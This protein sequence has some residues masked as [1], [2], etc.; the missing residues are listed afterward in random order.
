MRA[1]YFDESQLSAA[2]RDV[3]RWYWIERRTIAEVAD[4]LGVAWAT[5]RR[6]VW[7][8]REYARE[9]GAELEK[10]NHGRPRRAPDLEYVGHAD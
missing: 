3:Y 2:R 7:F 10:F 1:M 9:R 4:F 8:I 5:A 6:E